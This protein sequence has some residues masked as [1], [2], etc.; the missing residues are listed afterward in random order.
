MK[1]VIE[2]GQ[3]SFTVN[4]K[5]ISDKEPADQGLT[6]IDETAQN[7]T[8]TEIDYL[9]DKKPQKII[10]IWEKKGLPI[11]KAFGLLFIP[12]TKKLFLGGGSLLTILDVNS[13][14]KVVFEKNV[15]LF[16]SFEIVSKHIVAFGELQ[17]FLFS[18]DGEL[19][20]SCPVDP[21]YDIQYKSHEIIFTS[22]VYGETKLSFTQV[23]K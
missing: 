21:P 19:I 9:L 4:H 6:I 8:L 1:K 16:L 10:F 2:S 12:E 14:P 22:P 15:D 5:D 11:D 18:L 17:S 3:L 23:N 13:N 20:D 7:N